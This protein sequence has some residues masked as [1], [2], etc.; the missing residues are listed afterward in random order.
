MGRSPAPLPFSFHLRITGKYYPVRDDASLFRILDRF[1]CLTESCHMTGKKKKKSGKSKQE[2]AAMGLKVLAE[3][4]AFLDSVGVELQVK[5]I[6]H[7]RTPEVM[8]FC[9]RHLSSGGTWGELRRKLGLGPAYADRRWRAL[10][11]AIVEVALP[12]DEDD[13]LKAKYAT[14]QYLMSKLEAFFD[15]LETKIKAREGDDNEHHFIKLKLE[16]LK[17]MF[18]RNEI[19]FEHYLE[20]RRVKT[21][22][23]RNQGV[24]IVFQNIVKVPRPGDSTE[25]SV[26]VTPKRVSGSD[27][28]SE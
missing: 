28:S 7:T 27:S 19:D 13:A 6:A 4:Q 21:G 5:D 3:K 12:K 1:D 23:R 25:E 26:D 20:M 9:V 22:E 17:M 18:E 2:I 24:S 11:S 8:D 14:N 15:E 10:R 16:S